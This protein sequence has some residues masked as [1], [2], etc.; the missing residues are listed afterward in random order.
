MK[1]R[2]LDAAFDEDAVDIIDQL[3]LSSSRRPKRDVQRVNVDFPVWMV[4]S[5]DAEAARRRRGW[6]GY[7]IGFSSIRRLAIAGCG[8]S[9]GFEMA[10]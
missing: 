1:A 8:C 10:S 6:S 7:G 4:S 9:C 3:D 5:L 2:E